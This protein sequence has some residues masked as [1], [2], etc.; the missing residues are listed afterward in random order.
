MF[1]NLLGTNKWR[2]GVLAPNGKIYGMSGN[3]ASVLEIDPITQATGL[4]DN[5]P[6]NSKW[7][8]GVLSTNGRI[9]GM[10]NNDVQVLEISNVNT[11]SSIGSDANLPIDLSTLSTSKYNQYYNKF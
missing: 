4:L 2:G 7:Y 10:P 1:G 5:L 6:A 3:S 9:Y 8:G 11:P